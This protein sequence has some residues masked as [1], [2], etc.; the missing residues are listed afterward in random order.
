MTQLPAPRQT[1]AQ[2]M[3]PSAVAF[4][5]A[6]ED[7]RKFGGRIFHNTVT[8][9]FAGRIVPVN[10]KRQS[11]L[12]LPCVPLVS[13]ATAPVDVAVIAV[14]RELVLDHMRDCAQAGVACCVLI[15]AG[16]TETGPEGAALEQEIVA[17]ARAQGMRL[18]GPNCLG[19]INT[20]ASLIMNSSPSMQETAHIP[21]GIGF[22]SQSGA[23]MA[24]VYNRGVGDGARFSSAISVGNQADLELADFMEWMAQDE[25]TRCITLYV[26]GF[27]DA[28]RFVAAARRCREAGKP[29][30][31]VKSGRSEEGAR[32][33][34]SHTAS[35][36]GSWRVL[37]AVCREA[38]VV[39]VD[40]IIGMMQAAEMISR[41]GKPS[42]DGICVVSGSG[43][44]AAITT[45]RFDDVGLRLAQFSPAT[46][47][48]LEE[49]YEPHQLGNPLDLGAMRDR[50]FLDAKDGGIA[51][52]AADPDVAANLVMVTTAPQLTESTRALAAG[53]QDSGKPTLVVF[54]PGNASDGGRAAMREMGV[55]HYET[56]DEALRVLKCW[57]VPREAP[58]EAQRPQALPTGDPFAAFGPG[59][60]AEHE[61][62]EV[63]ARYGIRAT[64]ERPVGSARE[65]VMA[66]REIGW[67]VALKGFGPDIIHKSEEGAVAL[68]L[69][70]ET[71]LQTA[72]DLMARRLG[73]RLAGALVAEMARGE[74][75]AILGI[76]HDPQF[77]PVVLVGLGGVLAEVLD[78]VVLIPAPVSPERVRALLPRLRLWPL[79]EGVRGGPALDVDALADAASRLSWLAV[80]AGAR[81]AELDIN[82]LFLRHKGD[83]VIAV[84]ARARLD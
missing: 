31:M 57:L 11:L 71:Q 27:K 75:E 34:M 46:R 28:D 72:W 63:L 56:T 61:T 55:L 42:G 29:V 76:K 64:R 26:E 32:V 82:P 49:I 74:A 40:D 43:G 70:N 35:L 2:I 77:G 47:T 51:I 69:P 52:A 37:E 14:P 23:L 19:F 17:S 7:L 41:H 18:I 50:S 3:N 21:G 54:T 81:L 79:L 33:T 13:A 25:A 83:G 1:V 38:G 60:L 12:G 5:G 58:A 73:R 6:S 8:G 84:D 48:K 44:A 10:P 9:G 22:I 66:A 65:A 78:D 80:D 30:L 16:F 59:W 67:P 45:D 53:G 15:T 20:H 4:V 62:K 36:A 39:P 68:A 24:T